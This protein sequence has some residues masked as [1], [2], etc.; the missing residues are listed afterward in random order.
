MPSGVIDTSWITFNS[1]TRVVTWVKDPEVGFVGDYNITITGTIT[2][3][4]G[5]HTGSTNFILTVTLTCETSFDEITITNGG[6][7]GAKTYKLG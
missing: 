5:V 3:E 4:N 6:S 2:N 1:S 7:P